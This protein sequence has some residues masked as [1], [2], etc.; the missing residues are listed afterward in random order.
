[1]MRLILRS[2]FALLFLP[3]AGGIAMGQERPLLTEDVDVVKPGVV[4]I[5]TGFAFLQNQQ[6][7]LSGLRGNV[8]RLADTRMSF[9]LSPMVEFQIEWTARDFLSIKSRQ[10]SP[11]VL[12]PGLVNSTSDVVDAR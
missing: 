2:V 3:L 7:P 6:F 10:P 12:K 5:E 8:T 4:R 11:I 1:M 9:G